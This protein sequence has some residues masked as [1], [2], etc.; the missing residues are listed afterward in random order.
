MRPAPSG[1]AT[2]SINN[3]GDGFGLETW[4]RSWLPKRIGAKADTDLPHQLSRKQSSAF[5]SSQPQG[6]PLSKDWR[7]QDVRNKNPSLKAVQYSMPLGKGQKLFCPFLNA[8]R[9]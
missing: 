3:E 8:S 2:L 7:P 6:G 5:T 9:A 1:S 4:L